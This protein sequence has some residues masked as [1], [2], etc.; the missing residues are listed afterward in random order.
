VCTYECEADVYIGR[1]ICPYVGGANVCV[2]MSVVLMC[3]F[4]CAYV[5]MCV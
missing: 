4:T 2:H 3:I 5:H 1:C